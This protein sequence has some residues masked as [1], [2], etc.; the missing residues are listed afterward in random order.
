MPKSLNLTPEEKARRDA[1]F[2]RL[3]QEKHR[4]KLRAAQTA[5]GNDNATAAVPV[6]P[7]APGMP[8]EPTSDPN[9]GTP[10]QKLDLRKLR[11]LASAGN[12]LDACAAALNVRPE[13]VESAVHP[14]SWSDYYLAALQAGQAQIKLGLHLRAA[15]GDTRAVELL[16]QQEARQQERAGGDNVLL[17]DLRKLS[18]PELIKLRD[19]YRRVIA[20][21][22]PVLQRIIEGTHPTV[23]VVAVTPPPQP[24]STAVKECEQA[25]VSLG[26][27]L[28]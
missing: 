6:T 28:D 14:E 17:N 27:S 10:S 5:E 3:R 11:Q 15:T 12:D 26:F 13:D 16:N 21:K 7:A 19:E 23:R 4:A 24:D 2:N 20:W 9:L 22:S 18:L 1:E 25:Q 8:V